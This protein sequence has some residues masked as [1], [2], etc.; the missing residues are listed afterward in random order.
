[1]DIFLVRFWLSKAYQKQKV[2]EDLI[3]KLR[4]SYTGS[5]VKKESDKN[6]LKMYYD[7][8]EV[9]IVLVLKSDFNRQIRED[10]LQHI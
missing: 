8:L 3:P 7:G 1:M 5:Q 9:D 2:Y 4:K 10:K 6:V